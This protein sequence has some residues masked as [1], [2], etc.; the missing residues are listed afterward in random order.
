VVSG[1]LAASIGRPNRRGELEEMSILVRFSAVA[2][3]TQQYDETI[4]RLESDGGFPPDGLEYHCAYMADGTLRV[5]E[6]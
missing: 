4:T 6:V 1:Y 5:S 2:V 3:T